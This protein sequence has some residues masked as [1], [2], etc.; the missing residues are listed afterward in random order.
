[1]A[2]LLRQH[3]GRLAPVAAIAIHDAARD[4]GLEKVRAL[5]KQNPDL[6]LSKDAEGMTPLHW[7]AMQGRKDM[8]ELLIANRADINA[9][10]KYGATPLHVAV[11]SGRENVEELLRQ[12][13]GRE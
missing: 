4:G 7:A 2:E 13:G 11:L 8:A 3:G 1:M 5:L 10:N 9:K 12:H 6:A